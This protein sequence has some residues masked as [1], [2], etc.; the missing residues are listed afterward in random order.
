MTRVDTLQDRM[1][2]TIRQHPGCSL[3]DLQTSCAGWGWNQV[4]LEVDRMSR[5]GR[6][7]LRR[8]SVGVYRFWPVCPPE[9]RKGKENS[10][11][12]SREPQGLKSA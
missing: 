5:A 2:E 9:G 11:L 7:Q 12:N 6:I 10:N 3:E 4:F 8:D 1:L